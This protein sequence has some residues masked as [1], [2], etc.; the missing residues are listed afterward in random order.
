MRLMYY[1][2]LRT[3]ISNWGSA[4]CRWELRVNRRHCPSGMIAGDIY[5]WGPWNTHRPRTILGYCRGLTAGRHNLEVWVQNTPGYG[6]NPCYTGW[7]SQQTSWT[8]EAEEVPIT[9]QGRFFV[10]KYGPQDGRNQGYISGRT[11]PF[12]KLKKHTPVRLVYSDNLRTHSH[13]GSFSC[14]WEIR[15]DNRRCPSGMIAGDVYI[16]QRRNVHRPHQ[17]MGYCRGLSAGKHTAR[18]FVTNTPGYSRNSDCY[19]GW[20]S[21]QTSWT[22]E[23]TEML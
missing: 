11:L 15:V 13:G 22:M 8:L 23:A 1:D 5:I 2:N 12:T 14:R 20:Y 7:Y 21:Q 6:G 18:V 19:T 16:W 9:Q 3:H 4:S 17:I 10:T